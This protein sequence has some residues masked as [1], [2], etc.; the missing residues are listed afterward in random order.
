[1]R[2]GW[3]SHRTWASL[4]MM[5]MFREDGGKGAAKC[6]KSTVF[7]ATSPE[8]NGI[9]GRYFGSNTKELKVH[10]KAADPKAQERIL[11]VLEAVAPSDSTAGL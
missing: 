10:R 4:G 1:M 5:C 9:T 11:A 3:G 7:A 6:A 2:L 8:L